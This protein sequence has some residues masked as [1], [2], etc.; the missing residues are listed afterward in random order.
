MD[1]KKSED[2]TKGVEFAKKEKAL[3][4]EQDT[5]K[6]EATKLLRKCWEERI[7]F[8]NEERTR[9]NSELKSLEKTLYELESEQADS[10]RASCKELGHLY[11]ITN[12]QV[13]RRI[14]YGSTFLGRVYPTYVTKRCVC[15]GNSI[16]YETSDNGRITQTEVELNDEFKSLK[17]RITSEF[18]PKITEV[19]TQIAEKKS[20][21]EEINKSF[22]EV[23]RLFGHDVKIVN[24]DKE[25]YKC[26][27]CG[28]TLD[29][30][31]YIND[32]YNATYKNIIA[33]IYSDSGHSETIL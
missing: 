29:Y 19:K 12:V 10:L 22:Q 21:I 24:I 2:F 18:A 13:N 5:C 26:N 32:Y 23:C 16:T 1:W 25:V 15:C 8:L 30:R 31:E 6:K 27:C 4:E 9:L 11:K 7:S 14:S 28:K 33:F 3:K 17:K 20:E